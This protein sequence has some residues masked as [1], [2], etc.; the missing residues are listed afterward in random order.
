M[1]KV[2]IS[3]AILFSA[4]AF[5]DY[6]PHFFLGG[7]LGF[8]IEVYDDPFEEKYAPGG[9]LKFGTEAGVKFG[10]NDN[11]YNIGIAAFVDKSF[12]A[13]TDKNTAQ[14][15][16]NEIVEVAGGTGYCKVYNCSNIL[17]ADLASENTMYGI[18]VDNYIRFGIAEYESGITH[19]PYLVLGLG[20]ANVIHKTEIQFSKALNYKAS[21]KETKGAPVFRFGFA[22]NFNDNFGANAG[23]RFFIF[24]NATFTN[25]DVGMKY[26]F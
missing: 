21:N 13:S 25:F 22:L 2:V 8:D 17:N 23:M 14:E 26:T 4:P 3:M 18:I 16:A 20:Y 10:G 12:S 24:E 5:A 1:K 19:Y 9:H 15:Y 6:S 11:I 7:N